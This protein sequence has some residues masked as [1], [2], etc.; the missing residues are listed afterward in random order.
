[1]G[2]GSSSTGSLLEIDAGRG[3][4]LTVTNGF[5]IGTGSGSSGIL[6]LVAGADAAATTYTPI[7]AG[8][9]STGTVAYQPVGGTWNSGTHQFTVSAPV[10]GTSGSPTTIA[11]LSAQ[12]RMLITDSASKTSLGASF[13]AAAASGS[14]VTL[15]AST[16]TQASVSGPTLGAGQTVLSGWALTESGSGSGYSSSNPA[17]L[18]LSTAFVYP[19]TDEL[20]SS[21]NNGVN[22]TQITPNDLTFDNTNDWVSFGT[23][24]LNGYDYAVSGIPVLPGDVNLDGK[25]DI[26]D[27]TVVLANYG[28]TGQAWTQG[29]MNGD[30]TGTVDINDLTIVLGNYGN[31]VAA[32]GGIGM[33]AVP[34]PASLLLVAAALAGLLAYAWRKRK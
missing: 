33:S 11:D 8:T 25:V 1:M 3:S 30:P 22:W 32:S 19:G 26:N 23:P 20:W 13:L 18:S 2:T 27:L 15:T 4:T 29:S 28:K 17:Y 21:S 31:T 34:E 10:A 5:S 24:N 12:Q 7:S 6:R 16:L 9:W 14:T